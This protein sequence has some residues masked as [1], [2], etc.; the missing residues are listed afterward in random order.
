M[1][2]EMY[3]Q[4]NHGDYNKVDLKQYLQQE[5]EERPSE[6]L[7]IVSNRLPFSLAQRDDGSFVGKQSAGGLVTAM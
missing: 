4:S 3:I 7:Y 1:G 5:Q 2:A 6:T